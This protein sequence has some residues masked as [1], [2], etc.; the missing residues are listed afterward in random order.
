MRTTD[1]NTLKIVEDIL[2]KNDFL[3]N[4]VLNCPGNSTQE[5]ASHKIKICDIKNH[6]QILKAHQ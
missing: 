4:N 1:T 3:R 2:Q 6:P 5:L